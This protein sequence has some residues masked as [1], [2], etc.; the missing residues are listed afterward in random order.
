MKKKVQQKPKSEIDIKLTDAI[1]KKRDLLLKNDKREISDTEYAKQMKPLE[2][3]IRKLTQDKIQEMRNNN[4]VFGGEKKEQP[5]EKPV[6]ETTDKPKVKKTSKPKSEPL[7][8]KKSES[9][10]T[11]IIK[12]LK[13][14]KV[15]TSEK[16]VSIVNYWEPRFSKDNIRYYVRNVVSLIKN[17]NPRF[18]NLKWDEEKYMV[19]ENENE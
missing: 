19:I 15:D 13:H 4:A 18:P 5:I 12:A 3:E 8:D 6:K 14:P 16:V 11:L 7:P 10:I 2:D 1:A 17:N 9:C